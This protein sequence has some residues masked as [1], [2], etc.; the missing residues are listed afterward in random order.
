MSSTHKT[1][2]LAFGSAAFPLLTMGLSIIFENQ[3]PTFIGW[4]FVLLGFLFLV[5]IVAVWLHSEGYFRNF[6]FLY[7]LQ[8][9]PDF[10]A[11]DQH[12]SFKLYEAA[13]LAYDIKPNL[14]MPRKALNLYQRWRDEYLNNDA[15]HLRIQLRSIDNTISVAQEKVG[16]EVDYPQ[17]R[18]HPGLTV[19]N[20]ELTEW[21]KRHKWEPRFLFP[22]KRGE[23]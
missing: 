23:R 4:I 10:E 1:F 3:I 7:F 12:S 19:S 16:M 6:P 9:W 13:C 15:N 5:A 8:E 2:F 20:D 17:Y 22:F 18:F 21:F 11:Y 14:R